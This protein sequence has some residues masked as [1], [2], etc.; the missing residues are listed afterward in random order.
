MNIINSF[1]GAITLFINFFSP[2]TPLEIK[3]SVVNNVIDSPKTYVSSTSNTQLSLITSMNIDGFESVNWHPLVE[4]FKSVGWNPVDFKDFRYLGY[5]IEVSGDN[6]DINQYVIENWKIPDE[7]VDYVILSLK[8][9]D[10]ISATYKWKIVRIKGVLPNPL[11]NTSD[12]F[13][14]TGTIFDGYT[15]NTNKFYST[16]DWRTI[17]DTNNDW[18]PEYTLNENQNIVNV[19]NWFLPEQ[20]STTIWDKITMGSIWNI[21]GQKN[22]ITNYKLSKVPFISMNWNLSYI[23][24]QDYL[25]Y[26]YGSNKISSDITWFDIN[27]QKL[28]ESDLKVWIS[29]NSCEIISNSVVCDT[30]GKIAHVTVWENVVDRTFIIT[31]PN[32]NVWNGKNYPLMNSNEYLVVS[33]DNIG[34]YNESI[35]LNENDIDVTGIINMFVDW[36]QNDSL[37]VATSIDWKKFYI[38]KTKKVVYMV[39][40]DGLFKIKFIKYGNIDQININTSGNLTLLALSQSEI[41]NSITKRGGGTYSF[42]DNKN[43]L[44]V[45][46]YNVGKYQFLKTNSESWLYNAKESFYTKTFWQYWNWENGTTSLNDLKTNDLEYS[47]NPNTF[48]QFISVV[49]ND[50]VPTMN[51]VISWNIEESYYPLI[52][53]DDLSFVYW[54]RSDFSVFNIYPNLPNGISYEVIDGKTYVKFTKTGL[55]SFS[56]VKNY[57][58]IVWWNPGL[59]INISG[60]GILDVMDEWSWL[61]SFKIEKWLTTTISVEIIDTNSS[62]SNVSY[63]IPIMAKWS[64]VAEPTDGSNSIGFMKWNN[65][66]LFGNVET[67]DKNNFFRI[68]PYGYFSNP[69]DIFIRKIN[70]KLI[71]ENSNDFYIEGIVSESS[72]KINSTQIDGYNN[73]KTRIEW[74]KQVVEFNIT[75]FRWDIK[76]QNFLFKYN[77]KKVGN[78]EYN[79]KITANVTI[80]YTV[81]RIGDFTVSWINVPIWGWLNTRKLSVI[82]NSGSTSSSQTY[83]NQIKIK[84]INNDTWDIKNS[85]TSLNFVNTKWINYPVINS[86]NLLNDNKLEDKY[87]NMILDVQKSV[88]DP[89]KYD[90]QRIRAYYQWD[91]DL[92]WGGYGNWLQNANW[93]SSSEQTYMNGGLPMYLD[94]QYQ[95][96]SDNWYGASHYFPNSSNDYWNSGGRCPNYTSYTPNVSWITYGL[97]STIGQPV[98]VNTSI[99]KPKPMVE[100]MSLIMHFDNIHK[101]WKKNNGTP[102]KIDMIKPVWDDGSI[103]WWGWNEYKKF[104]LYLWSDSPLIT[105]YSAQFSALWVTKIPWQ[106]WGIQI[107]WNSPYISYDVNTT[108]NDNLVYEDWMKILL[109]SNF[110]GKVSYVQLQYMWD[111]KNAIWGIEDTEKLSETIQGWYKHKNLIRITIKFNNAYSD[112]YTW[113]KNSNSKLLRLVLPVSNPWYVWFTNETTSSWKQTEDIFPELIKLNNYITGGGQLKYDVFFNA[114]QR[115]STTIQKVKLYSWVNQTEIWRCGKNGCYFVWCRITSK[116]STLQYHWTQEMNFANWYYYLPKIWQDGSYKKLD[117]TW[118]SNWNI[119]GDYRKR[120]IINGWRN[121]NNVYTDLWTFLALRKEWKIDWSGYREYLFKSSGVFSLKFQNIY[122]PITI[123]WNFILPS[124][125][126]DASG[127]LKTEWRNRLNLSLENTK[128]LPVDEYNEIRKTIFEWNPKLNKPSIKNYFLNNSYNEVNKV[129]GFLD[130]IIVSSLNNNSKWKV[131]V[132]YFGNKNLTIEKDLLI[133]YN[134]LKVKSFFEGISGSSQEKSIEKWMNVFITDWDVFIN[135]NVIE[136]W[137]NKDIW[138]IIIAKNVVFGSKPQIFNGWIISDEMWVEYNQKLFILNWGVT[139]K[140]GIQNLWCE[141]MST[142]KPE[143]SMQSIEWQITSPF[144]FSDTELLDDTNAKNLYSLI[145]LSCTIINNGKYQMFVSKWEFLEK[146]K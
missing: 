102:Y 49:W 8:S 22:W 32:L 50:G 9:E 6:N 38:N 110:N 124:S 140:S 10:T 74:G 107:S 77:L 143:I 12:A 11:F 33:M 134:T 61:F 83:N 103:F 92:E 81:W 37:I 108:W 122:S 120:Y 28:D 45:K 94:N 146:T 46:L 64:E 79:G 111:Y 85:S 26:N 18:T 104:P 126:A 59:N 91:N 60:E 41:E 121:P 44:W 68:N 24:W 20:L 23:V 58:R 89:S 95:Y 72:K 145:W 97:I 90:N 67:N 144:Q 135:W 84:V 66:Q 69:Y 125:M 87:F 114:K 2:V 62:I 136:K 100:E 99:G 4:W 3:E 116:G 19:E 39:E 48:S 96:S 63:I 73:M 78:G 57:V 105:P 34:S 51:T 1:I 137:Y 129:N 40:K 53:W 141:R 101:T 30:S 27:T 13:T 118:V 42:S 54:L 123:K 75:N 71:N 113:T 36:Q 130:D 86:K 117:N 35:P 5:V 15:Y 52:Y 47:N 17:L 133:D 56:N 128:F 80:D 112:L 14:S 29:N 16:K 93:V 109:P 142:Q 65:P 98:S 31:P 76:W 132:N 106:T 21:Y 55:D 43:I 7:L 88:I 25:I 115:Y 82:V 127:N 138:I 131:K 139:L 70:V 119:W